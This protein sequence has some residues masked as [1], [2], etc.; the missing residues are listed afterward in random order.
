M[1]APQTGRFYHRA[2][3]S[4]PPFVQSGS[5]VKEGSALGLI[6]VMKTFSQVVYRAQGLRGEPLPAQ[7]RIV[8]HLVPDGAEVAQGD[9]LIEVAP[10]GGA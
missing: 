8:A 7:A 9:P 2:R 1:L 10:W 6:E 4:D 3:P 5:Q